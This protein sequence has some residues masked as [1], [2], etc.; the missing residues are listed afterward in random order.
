MIKG[1]HLN[2]KKVEDIFL[3]KTDLKIFSLVLD[4]K[5]KILTALDVHY[6][7][8]SQPFIHVEKVLRKLVALEL[9]M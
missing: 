3:N 2:S 9:N 7:V 1:G 6:Q 8:Q 4:T 5:Q